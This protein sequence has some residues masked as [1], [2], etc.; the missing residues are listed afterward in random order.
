MSLS[1]NRKYKSSVFV[2]YF[3]DKAKLIEVCNA[4]QGT[5]YPKDTA[6]QINTL[7]YALYL[8]RVNDISFSI[9]NKLLVL[10]EHQSTVNPNMPLRLLLYAARVYEKIL[11]NKNIY[12]TARIAI[13]KPEFLVLYNGEADCPDQ[14][15][16]KLSDAFMEADTQ[17]LLELTVKVYNIN[18]GRNPKILRKSRSLREYAAFIA[19]IRKNKSKSKDQEEAIREAIVYCIKHGIMKDFLEKN[20]SEVVNMLSTEFS[21]ED[22]LRI[23][24]EE[25]IEKGI[26][27]DRLQIAKKMIKDGDSP[28]K[29]VRVTE[30]PIEII[31]SIE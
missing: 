10:I 12:T 5:N 27:Q 18:Q 29:I 11:D 30:L 8:N 23:R 9:D 7:E 25:G 15:I 13:P 31:Q 24:Y 22:A 3:Q 19:R 14:S 16:L 6:V 4:F 21:L 17:G 2:S 20:G 1:T 26:E 28:E